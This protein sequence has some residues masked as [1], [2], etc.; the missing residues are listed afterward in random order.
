MM[1]KYSKNSLIFLTTACVVMGTGLILSFSAFTTP[2]KEST[3]TQHTTSSGLIY[4]VL[5]PAPKDALKPRSG[6]KVVVHYTGWL[7]EQGKPGKKFDS[8][9]DRKEPF[10]FVVGKG[11]VIKGWDET[12]LDM[13]VG[14]KR[15]ITIPPALGYGARGI[16]T[17]I[18]PY[19]TLIFDVELISI[20]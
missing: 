2:S 9:L 15:R 18:P 19:S 16:G 3:M 6:Q 8:S 14:E 17:L 7:E 10:T 11:Q 5:T 4:Q 20:Q 1:K 13:H 12:L